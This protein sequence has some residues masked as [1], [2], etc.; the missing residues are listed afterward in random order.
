MEISDKEKEDIEEISQNNEQEINEFQIQTTFQEDDDNQ[1]K[2]RKSN[3]KLTPNQ[4][5]RENFL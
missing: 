5:Y 4:K 2:K 1:S 3:R